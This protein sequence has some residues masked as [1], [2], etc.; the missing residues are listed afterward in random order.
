MTKVIA[1]SAELR[2]MTYLMLHVHGSALSDGVAIVS[3]DAKDV[4]CGIRTDN[5]YMRPCGKCNFGHCTVPLL[6]SPVV[7]GIPILIEGERS[8]YF[9][10]G[11]ENLT[12]PSSAEVKERLEKLAGCLSTAW[13]VWRGLENKLAESNGLISAMHHVCKTT[14]SQASAEEVGALLEGALG[15]FCSVQAWC[16]YL[17]DSQRPSRFL[18]TTSEVTS[19]RTDLAH[20]RVLV[21][22]AN[23]Q[24]ESRVHA[25]D[26]TSELYEKV[27][28]HLVWLSSSTILERPIIYPIPVI[29]ENPDMQGI[30]RRHWTLF[31]VFPP[32]TRPRSPW[33]EHIRLFAR[34]AFGAIDSASRV[35][36][37]EEKATAA[38]QTLLAVGT[39]DRLVGQS[40]A[41]INVREQILVAARSDRT[42]LLI[43]EPGT[44]KEL[45]AKLIHQHSLRATYDR[46]CELVAREL[47]MGRRLWKSFYH[48]G[49]SPRDVIKA[50]YHAVPSVDSSLI[51]ESMGSGTESVKTDYRNWFPDGH[52]EYD[53]LFHEVQLQAGLPGQFEHIYRSVL[54]MLYYAWQQD[55]FFNFFEYDSGAAKEN[56]VTELFG[57]ASETFTGVKGGPGRFQV[58]SHCGG[59]IF[60]D[61]IHHLDLS[62]QQAL[63]KATEIRHE[64]RK[65]SRHGSSTSEPLQVRL[66]VAT[67]ADLT[68]LVDEGRFLKEWAG[69]LSCQVIRLPAMRERLQDIP[70]LAGHF[71]GLCG[72]E[73]EEEA[74]RPLTGYDWHDSNVRG[75]QN[76]IESAADLTEESTIRWCHIDRAMSGLLAESPKSAITAE[77]VMIQDALRNAKGNKSTAA[78]VIGWK[79]QKLYRMMDEYGI[80]PD[81]G[82]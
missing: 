42:V 53:K 56:A 62:V 38:R 27:R 21:G 7:D 66:I 68:T 63:L 35:V 73:I 2:W 3:E 12:H 54:R 30:P 47:S 64:D 43:G 45:V 60:L 29:H 8:G 71:A 14:G 46:V 6:H 1:L 55:V 33:F 74:L 48:S 25:L 17:F 50:E 67:T 15:D 58:A 81:Y 26:E 72:K 19:S 39:F 49:M 82:R 28:S 51:S 37:A 16:G 20:L 52:P 31:A 57:V 70:M 78:K 40:P 79:R 77:K 9:A 23:V 61:N 18:P 5:W 69:R 10:V 34:L 65:V 80:A 36:Q 11:L 13:H 41:M 22:E 32:E 24:C 76:V 44:G 75:L 4:I 59:T